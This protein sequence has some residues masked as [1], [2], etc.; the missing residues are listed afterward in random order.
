MEVD[1]RELRVVVQHL[2]EVRH[3]PDAR[4]SR[5][6]GTRRRAGRGCRRRPS[7]RACAGRSPV[8]GHRRSAADRRSRNSI[9]IGCGNFGAL[10]HPPLRVSNAVDRCAVD[11]RVEQRPGAGV[12]C[13]AARSRAAP[14]ARRPAAPPASSTLGPSARAR[15]RSTPSS[16]WR[17]DGIPCRGVVREV[18]AAVERP[19]VRGQEHGHRP[20]AA[21]GHRLDRAH[22][23][24]VEVRALLA[25]H[26]DRH[27]MLVEDRAPWPRPRTTRA[28]SRGTSGRPRSRSTGR[29]A[30]PAASRGPSASGPHGYQ[31]TGLCACWSRYG[32]VSPARRFVWRCSVDPSGVMPRWYGNEAVG[33]V[34]CGRVEALAGAWA[35]RR[36]AGGA[37]AWAGRRG[38][39]GAGQRRGAEARGR[40]ARQRREAPA[41]NVQI[42][43]RCVLTRSGR[44][45]RCKYAPGAY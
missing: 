18:R 9:V 30:G 34:T 33:T 3:E 29:S 20:A 13:P 39:G 6:G 14:R 26:L 11:R 17:N 41:G 40:G 2:L 15:R 22:V 10:P 19:A 27:E 28:P 31:S 24:L 38:V 44:D 1:A 25:I 12:A 45:F 32:L 16:T 43:P 7:R 37:G 36:G 23:E 21:A 4:R 5:S 8:R 42:R 35:G